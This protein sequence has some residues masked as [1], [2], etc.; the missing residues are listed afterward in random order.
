MCVNKILQVIQESQ[1][2]II[3][4]HQNPDGDA[5]G[6]MVAM[7]LLCAAYNV[8]YTILLEEA[9]PSQFSDLFE[10]VSVAYE[11]HQPWDTMIALDC[12][13]TDR[14]VGYTS[15]FLKSQRTIVIDHHLTNTAYGQYNFVDSHASS[16]SEMVYRLIKAS[17]KPIDTKLAEALYTGILT[18]TGGFMHSCTSPE[19]MKIASELIAC[20]FDFSS[21]Y[22][23]LIHEKSLLGAQLQGLAVQHLKQVKKGIYLSYISQEDM[24]QLGATKQD[25]DGIVSYLKNIKGVDVIAVVYPLEADNTYK[26]STRC[27]LPYNM[28]A[29]CGLF[30]GGGHR[31]AAGAKIEGSLS[32][33]LVDLTAKLMALTTDVE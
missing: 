16:T 33:V 9:Y 4:G 8:P 5:I 18:D 23:K 13:D 11:R 25:V 22:Q 21:R 24:H 7:G 26:L 12:G 28:A 30:K 17:T 20:G 6:A 29:F 3:S 10:G 15:Y 32:K 1:H 19:T 31:L 27:N 2:I 14:L